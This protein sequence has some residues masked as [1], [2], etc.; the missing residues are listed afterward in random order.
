MEWMEN[1]APIDELVPE[2][3]VDIHGDWGAYCY[4]SYRHSL[5]HGWSSG[6][7]PFMSRYIL[8]VQ[9]EEPGCRKLRIEP[10]LGDLDFAKGTYPTPYGVVTVSHRK[11]KD[12]TIHTEVT[13]P[14]GV[15]ILR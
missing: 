7:C 3:M 4:L 10:H 2:G 8:G 1:A 13:A 14:D 11:L 15:E 9:V 5:C 12:G 6:P